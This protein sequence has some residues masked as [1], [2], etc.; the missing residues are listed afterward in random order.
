M[1]SLGLPFAR[2]ARFAERDDIESGVPL[3]KDQ[4]HELPK[5]PIYLGLGE[6]R[7]L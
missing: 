1:T 5:R 4:P 3:M 6:C 7:W 2:T